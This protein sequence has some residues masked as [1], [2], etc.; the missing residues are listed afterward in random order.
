MIVMLIWRGRGGGTEWSQQLT[1]AG[2][3]GTT[4][5]TIVSIRLSQYAP[6]R[7]PNQIPP[8]YKSD[9]LI[10]MLGLRFDPWAF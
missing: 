7:D 9:V 5:T 4:E 10:N 1:G 6:V 8:E 3:Q 2:M